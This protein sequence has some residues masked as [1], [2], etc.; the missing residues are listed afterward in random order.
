MCVIG[1]GTY[2]NQEFAEAY[3]SGL[4]DV[5]RLQDRWYRD[6]TSEE[7]EVKRKYVIVFDES[8]ENPIMNL[9]KYFSEKYEVDERTYIDKN[10]DQIF[11]LYRLSLVAHNA[12]G[13]DSWAVLI[14]LV[15]EITEL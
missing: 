2:I 3:A 10:G 12:R 5:N 4:Y 9:L 15:E 1:L 13:F 11:S 6:L 14:S 8:C 7:I